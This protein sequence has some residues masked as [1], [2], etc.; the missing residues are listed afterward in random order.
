VAAY[1]R[2]FR[3]QQLEKMVRYAEGG[4]CRISALIAHF[5]DVDDAGRRCG[6]CDFCA[7]EH[8]IAQ[9]FRPLTNS[10]KQTVLEI[11]RALRSVQHIST[12][13]L[14]KQ[15]FPR[16]QMHRDEFEVLLAA[17]ARGGYATLEDA[18]FEKDGRAVAYRRV[19]LTD[20][21][22]ELRSAT[23]LCLFIPD[24]NSEPAIPAIRTAPGK[25]KAGKLASRA[26]QLEPEL[27]P[28]ELDLE[29]R[30]RAWR[31]EEAKRNSFPAFRI[32]GDKTLR[33]VVLD[34]PTTIQDLLHVSGIGPEKAAK[35]GADI[36]AICA[37]M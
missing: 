6:L 3:Q 12:G 4:R 23:R 28:A 35:F 29:K 18:E 8:C 32:F 26:P 2:S 22:E 24:V 37:A 17:M 19:G 15:L 7:P 1:L 14:H 27:T 20:E 25:S 31:L 10:E 30:L 9:A 5:G 21:G 11:A 33:A 34:R 36:C 16:E 13:K